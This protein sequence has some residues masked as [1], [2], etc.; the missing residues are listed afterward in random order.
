MT[1]R[2]ATFEHPSGNGHRESVS[3]LAVLWA[4]LFGCFFF[5]WRGV[6]GHAVLSLLVAIVTFGLG[7]LVYA[8]LAPAVLLGSYRRRGWFEV[9]DGEAD[10]PQRRRSAG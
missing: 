3:H 9:A 2:I 7:W 6:W 4:L 10:P 1:L 5:A 8:L